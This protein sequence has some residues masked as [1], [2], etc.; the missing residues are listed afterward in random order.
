MFLTLERPRRGGGDEPI[1][2]S[3]L[4]FEAFKQSKMKLSVPVV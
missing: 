1:G 4:K 2:F 3:E